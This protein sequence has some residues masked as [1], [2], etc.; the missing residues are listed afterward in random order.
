MRLCAFR[1]RTWKP[2]GPALLAAAVVLV[3]SPAAPEEADAAG[4][5]AK[6]D[7]RPA[8]VAPSEV[9]CACAARGSKLAPTSVLIAANVQCF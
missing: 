3:E 7:C 8:T 4:M 6:P 1:R 9:R 2:V 5:A